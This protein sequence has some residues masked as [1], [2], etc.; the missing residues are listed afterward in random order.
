MICGGGWSMDK[1]CCMCRAVLDGEGLCGSCSSGCSV[2][3]VG[4]DGAGKPSAHQRSLAT[5]ICL[6][7]CLFLWSIWHAGLKSFHVISTAV[8][9]LTS[10]VCVCLCKWKSDDSF[11]LPDKEMC[12]MWGSG[13]QRQLS[14]QAMQKSHCGHLVW[15]LK[16]GCQKTDPRS[17]C[18]LTVFTYCS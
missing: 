17:A 18:D 11:P 6:H 8:H 7:V 9:N 2:D 3:C 1:R 12:V 15:F 5:N 10:N 13:R 4:V 14:N 16:A